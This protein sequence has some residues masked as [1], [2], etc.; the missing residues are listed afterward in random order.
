MN[1]H[2]SGFGLVEIIVAIALFVT[3]AT[4]GITTVLGSFSSNRLG[5]EETEAALVAQEGIEAARSIVKKG[6]STPFLATTC[7]G[8]C[9]VSSSSGSWIWSGTANVSSPFNRQI[10]VSSVQRNGSGDVVTSGGTD[11]PDT[12]KITSRVSWNFTS[13]RANIVE[14]VTYVTNFTKSLL[15]NWALPHVLGLFDFTVGNSGNATANALSVAYSNGYVYV[16]RALSGGTELIAVNIS[17]P[18][19]P[20]VCATCTRELNGNVNDIEINGN[21]AYIASSNNTQELQ[22]ISISTPTALSTATLTTV[23]LTVGNSGNATVDPV[24]ISILGTSLY[25]IRNGGNEFIR[26]NITNPAAPTIVGTNSQYTGVPSDMV[27]HSNYAYVTGDGNAT[28]LTTFD[29]S[30]LSRSNLLNINSG[31]N[32][33]NALSV[34]Q[35]GTNRILVGRQVSGAPELYTLD[36]ST[37]TNPTIISTAEIGFNVLDIAFGSNLIFIVTNDAPAELKIMDGTNVDVLPTSYISTLNLSDF[38][39]DLTYDTTLDMAFSVGSSNNPELQV[40]QGQ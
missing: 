25:M 21:Y 22:I 38:P 27:I 30:T 2:K 31:D 8:G 9:G 10:Y 36:I 40:L 17:N 13:A 15:S 5:D 20:T 34:I 6:W 1:N 19:S 3:I 23:D 4:V 18:A 33:A 16:G 12:K 14:L 39:A 26:F 28:E 37:P 32:N 7:S 24:A 11:D 35:A 29:T